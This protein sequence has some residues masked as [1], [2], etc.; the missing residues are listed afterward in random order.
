MNRYL[1]PQWMPFPRN[2]SRHERRKTG[3]DNRF[4]L[5]GVIPGQSRGERGD[6]GIDG[7]RALISGHRGGSRAADHEVGEG[8]VGSE[9][10]Q[11]AGV[12]EEHAHALR[13]S[14]A[15]RPPRGAHP[16]HPGHPVVTGE[17]S[18][19]G[20]RQ[21]MQAGVRDGPLDG[22]VP[23]ECVAQGEVEQVIHASSTRVATRRHGTEPPSDGTDG[24]GSQAPLIQRLGE[25]AGDVIHVDGAGAAL[26]LAV[27]PVARTPTTSE[28]R[29]PG[30]PHNVGFVE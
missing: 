3:C 13:K 15:V 28:H 21:I 6:L 19:V 10:I 29:S 22:R 8:V 23:R 26:W 27:L 14:K 4:A 20:Q 18:V 7:G 1:A 24:Q 16:D 5:Y 9:R 25:D 11:S 30:L 17:M 2:H 12:G